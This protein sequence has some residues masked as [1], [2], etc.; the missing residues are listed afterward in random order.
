MRPPRRTP[1]LLPACLLLGALPLAAAPL[2]AAPQKGVQVDTGIQL[3]PR[4]L[5][6]ERGDGWFLLTAETRIAAAGPARQ[7]AARL[8]DALAET[9]GLVLELADFE[10][11]GAPTGGV[12]L[13]LEPGISGIGGEGYL[14]DVRPEQVLLG[15]TTPVGLLHGVQT[16]RQLLPLPRVIGQPEN[17]VRWVLPAVHVVDR[18]RFSWRGLMLDCSR[19]FQS[20]EYLR[21]TIDRMEF[22][23]LNVLHLHLTD[24]QGW[25]LE[26]EAFPE[27]TELGARFA[28][29]FA[30]PEAHQG[31][32][33][34]AEITDLVSYAAAR[35]VTIVPEIEMPGHA[36]AA[37]ACHPELSCTGGPFEIHPF[38]EGPGIHADVFCPG[39]DATFEFLEAVLDEVVELFPSRWIHIGGDE[40]PVERWRACERCRRRIAEEG[41]AGERALQGW[42]TRRIAGYLVE[43]GRVPLGW[44]EVLEAGLSQ[45]TA[46]MSWRGTK[47]GVEA[48]RAGHD[49]VMSP[50]SHCYFDYSWDRIDTERA[51]AF[52]PVP[53]ELDEAAARHVLGLQANFWSHIDREP[54]L[55]DRQLFPRLLAIAERGWSARDV[56]DQ[57]DFRWR[58]EVHLV[59][60]DELGVAYH[61]PPP[62]PLAPSIGTWSPAQISEEYAP[63]TW[64]V[65]EHVE[66]A[67]RYRVRFGYT[68][69]SHRLGIERVE[70]LV[71]GVVAARDA[72]RGT[73]GTVDEDNDYVLEL[74]A[75]PATAAI[76]LRASARSEGGTDSNGEVYLTREEER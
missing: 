48:A 6:V 56:R 4:P 59:H 36:L 41:L 16:L 20:V 72:H 19:T 29:R 76:T 32:Y 51:Y 39:N 62:E 30:E 15:A 5:A 50:T 12:V 26:L 38:G 40:V 73:T 46:V 63:L 9:T 14:L 71:D 17:L 43:K 58:V 61:R 42:F 65:T 25:R 22:Y 23:K 64:D 2:A 68:H 18:P 55:V 24:D 27:L 28:D 66:G 44:D 67:G 74:G 7:V 33:T 47:G 53:E 1:R 69:G 60:L 31:Y 49:V 52:E 35:G 75:Y 8:R 45:D 11:A 10:E 57:E 21:R 3:I 70:L 34:K 37:L 54:A 13:L